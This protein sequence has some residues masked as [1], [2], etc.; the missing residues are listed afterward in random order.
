[1][2]DFV[3]FLKIFGL[4]LKHSRLREPNQNLKK[5]VKFIKKDPFNAIFLEFFDFIWYDFVKN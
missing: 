2:K 1:M 4:R 5:Q 3:I